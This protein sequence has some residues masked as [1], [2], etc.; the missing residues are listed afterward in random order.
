MDNDRRTTAD[1]RPTDWSSS[2]AALRLDAISGHVLLVQPGQPGQPGHCLA[3]LAVY[4]IFDP[5]DFPLLFPHPQAPSG[6]PRANAGWAA[7]R[8]A[9][10]ADRGL[11]RR[12]SPNIN[13]RGYRMENIPTRGPPAIWF[14]FL[15]PQ[16]LLASPPPPPRTSCKAMS[17]M[18]MDRC[19]DPRMQWTRCVSTFS[20]VLSYCHLLLTVSLPSRSPS[21]PPRSLSLSLSLT[22]PRCL[23]KTSNQHSLAKFHTHVNLLCLPLSFRSPSRLTMDRGSSAKDLKSSVR[24]TAERSILFLIM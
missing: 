7:A 14:R 3:V 15:N 18:T 21:P 24:G 12:R 6:H 23:I 9:A 16:A 19:W 10:R 13:T 22:L 1:D 4:C 17:A 11:C 20:F 5:V 8:P 2:S